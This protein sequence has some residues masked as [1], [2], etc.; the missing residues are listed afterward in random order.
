MAGEIPYWTPDPT[1]HS[2]LIDRFPALGFVPCPGDAPEAAH[3]TAIVTRTA[4]A[5]EDISD[6]LHGTKDG[7]WVGKHANAFREQFDDNFRPKVDAA[8][9]SFRKAATALRDWSKAM[10]E[11]QHKA[12]ILESK[13]QAALDTHEAMKE[14]LGDLPD[15]ASPYDIPKNDAEARKREQVETERSSTELAA[16]S[17]E[18]DL[19][20][21]RAH[22][23]KLA[24]D[25]AIE[26]QS[27][28]RRLDKAL[29]LAPEEPGA[30]DKL[31]DV[32]NDIGNALGNLDDLVKEVLSDVVSDAVKWLSEH[33]NAIAAIGDV[34]ATISAAL[35]A[36]SLV[37]LFLS[38][39]FPPLA[40]AST[41][42]AAGSG[43]FALGALATHGTARAVG[44]ESVVSNRT[45]AQDVLGVIPL[46]L[47]FKGVSAVVAGSRAGD[48]VGN[49]GLV[50]TVAGFLSD[51][52]ALGYFKPEN[53]RQ[54]A[55]A[56]LPGGP[57]LVAFENAWKA[58]SAKD[59]T[60]EQNK[61][62]S[63]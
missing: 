5:L 22:A 48:A 1:S 24:S 60:Q 31:G 58:G 45:L 23:R 15:R 47:G 36:L 8:K 25:Y 19:E 59:R 30:L 50:D 2:T 3:I 43:A 10:P 39:L 61:R 28:A 33:A 38:P 20:K 46:G 14:K 55:T 62:E 11:W 32:L 4:K 21:I 51:P 27:V 54:A 40:I 56:V 41:A 18:A 44:G 57:I 17:A 35:G 42:V 12:L 9:N 53:D 16:R 52:T 13:A 49:F 63:S 26:G 7:D 34:L 6:V 29:E 37:L